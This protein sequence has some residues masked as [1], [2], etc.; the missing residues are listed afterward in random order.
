MNDREQA[1]AEIRAIAERA[2]LSADDVHGALAPAAAIPGKP[3]AR[4][5]PLARA[6]AYIGGTFVLSGIAVFVGMQWQQMNSAERIIVTLGSGIAAFVL[7]LLANGPAKRARFV[8]PLFLIAAI[9]GLTAW[10]LRKSNVATAAA[11]TARKKQA[12]APARS[13]SCPP[14]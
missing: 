3:A 14:A 4:Q 7:A 9:C 12:E 13:I 11:E 2:G 5:G 10:M 1:L 6:L 8:T